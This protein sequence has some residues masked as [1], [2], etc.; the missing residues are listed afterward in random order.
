MFTQGSIITR[1][2]VKKNICVYK[3]KETKKGKRGTHNALYDTILTL[4]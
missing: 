1:H 2:T 4:L 3:H